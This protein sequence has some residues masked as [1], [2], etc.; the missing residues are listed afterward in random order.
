M[1]PTD[2][3]EGLVEVAAALT[4]NDTFLIAGIGMASRSDLEDRV[5]SILDRSSC[6]HPASAAVPRPLGRHRDCGFGPWPVAPF[7]PVTIAAVEPAN[8]K[9]LATEATPAA[10]QPADV[11]TPRAPKAERSKNATTTGTMRILVIDS[12]DQPIPGAK[13]HANV[14]SDPKVPPNR[15]YIC[16]AHGEVD[17][18]LPST[19]SLLR[20][21][22]S[23]EGYA[24]L[25]AQWWPEKQDD[26]HLIPAAFTF[27]MP[28]GTVIGG[29][30]K[31][32]GGVPIAGVHVEVMYNMDGEKTQLTQRPIFNTWLA[33]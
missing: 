6:R 28:K 19:L 30:V 16:D 7:S 22:V 32:E 24:S 4:R 8:P 21:W 1:Q 18:E 23:K 2:Y 26:G 20:L 13:I 29:I 11:K 3:A 14:S 25:F 33:G 31:D 9:P 5:R 10:A 17:V 27:R 12:A 15:D